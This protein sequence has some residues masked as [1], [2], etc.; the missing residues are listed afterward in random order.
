VELAEGGGLSIV[1]LMSAMNVIRL[2][3]HDPH[4]VSFMRFAMN[5]LADV[6]AAADGESPH[7]VVRWG[8][9]VVR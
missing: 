3:E 9:A 8:A 5:L 2:L 6:F 1:H 7:E 4:D